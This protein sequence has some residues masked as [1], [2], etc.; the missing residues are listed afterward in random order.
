MTPQHILESQLQDI[1]SG[2]GDI[3]II[4]DVQN[5]SINALNINNLKVISDTS[6]DN[7]AWAA[8]AFNQ[9]NCNDNV[10]LATIEPLYLKQVYTHK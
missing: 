1:V 6:I 4:T 3:F 7:N 5:E 9:Y 8:Y 2:N 10:N